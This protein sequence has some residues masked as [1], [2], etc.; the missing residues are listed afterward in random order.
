MSIERGFSSA[1]RRILMF[2]GAG[3]AIYTLK[4][5]IGSASDA[6]E[7]MNK[8]NVVFG[9]N[10]K[11]VSKWSEEFG[12]KVGRA[13]QDVQKWMAGVQDLFVPLGF[14]RDKATDLSKSVVQLAVDVGSFSNIA[15]G[16]VIRDFNSALV[17][18]HE[19]V[20]KYG[21]IISETSLAQEALNQNLGKAYKDLTDLEKVQ[22]RYTLIQKGSTD[23]QGDAIRSADDYANQMWRLKANL[24]ETAVE[25]GGPFM[26]G[27]S[28]ILVE[29]NKQASEWK[30]FFR[31]QADGW[32]EIFSGFEN[33]R[34][35]IREVS[36]DIEEVNSKANKLRPRPGTFGGFGAGTM[37][38]PPVPRSE[39]E[40][41]PIGKLEISPRG[42][43]RIEE[44]NNRIREMELEDQRKAFVGPPAPPEEEIIKR[45]Q[46]DI[47]LN[48]D[49]QKQIYDDT[50]DRIEAV[51]HM[52][53]LT[54]REKIKNLEIYRD[55][56]SEVLKEV[57]AAERA[58]NDEIIA[59]EQSR[60]NAMEVYYV[61]LREQ[62][63]ETALYISEKF[64]D[65]ARSIEGS[66]ANAFDSMISEGADFK[67]ATKGFFRDVG[68]AFSRMA[69]EM[70]AEMIMLYIMRAIMGLFGGGPGNQAGSPWHSPNYSTTG[71]TNAGVEPA[72][73]SAYGNAFYKGRLVPMSDGYIFHRPTYFPMADGKVGL[74]GEGGYEAALP[75]KRMPSGRLGVESSGTQKAAEPPVV[76]VKNIIV[77]NEREAALEAMQSEDGKNVTI[78]TLLEND[79]L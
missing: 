68:K 42:Y 37:G 49:A 28:N 26:E 25:L 29:I 58:L 40:P 4:K 7:T 27:L 43:Q 41:L 32:T 5:F 62:V 71:P 9:K 52:H 56:H 76:V 35:I 78:N 55:T 10:A 70:L 53:Y 46:D 74:I 61:E 30:E 17:G 66:M 3:G 36:R 19:T 12:D 33:V 6:Q 20:R 11:E 57:S 64:A 63:E 21:I 18:N 47:K 44:M 23:A 14:A 59:Y 8:F 2:A 75:L 45:Q 67:D 34:T 72:W 73:G 22:L 50:R 24:H 13:T 60:V 15:T 16:D 79:L 77:R 38:A 39:I 65:T 51:R 1:M 48:A 31:I 69:S 54:R